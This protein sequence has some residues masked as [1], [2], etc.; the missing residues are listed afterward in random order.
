MAMSNMPPPW[1]ANACLV[2]SDT[3]EHHD[4]YNRARDNA[5]ALPKAIKKSETEKAALEATRLAVR[6]ELEARDESTIKG[7]K[8]K[9]VYGDEE[10][11][12]TNTRFAEIGA[13]IASDKA[14]LDKAREEIAHFTATVATAWE[15]QF[16]EPFPLDDVE[17]VELWEADGQIYELHAE[18]RVYTYGNYE[19]ILAPNEVVE[20]A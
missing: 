19:G 8:F 18:G 3:P 20:A 13:E 17:P 6:K 16:G 5:T 9:A 11:E 15:N 10:I 14:I 7:K 2:W 4:R 1:I 12:K